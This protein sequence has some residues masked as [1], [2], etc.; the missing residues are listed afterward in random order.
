MP[1]ELTR[2]EFKVLHVG[3]IVERCSANARTPLRHCHH[4]QPSDVNKESKAKHKLDLGQS[5]FDVCN[6]IRSQ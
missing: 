4:C 1:Y 5:P 2:F 6:L 3:E